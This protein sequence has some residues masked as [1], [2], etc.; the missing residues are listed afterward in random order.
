MV[1]SKIIGTGS[2]LPEKIV[3]NDDMAKFV[4]TSDEWISSRTGIKERRFAADGQLTSELAYNAAIKALK[5]AQVDAEDIDMII[6]ATTTP[7]NTFPSTAAKLHLLLKINEN[8]PTFD[9]QA[10]CS[11]FVYGLS[12]ADSMIK[13]HLAKRILLVG[14]ETMSRILDFNDRATCVL[15][16][17]GAGA[18]VL[19]ATNNNPKK[20]NNP[21][22]LST[23][24]HSN[25]KHYDILKVQGGPSLG[26]EGKLYMDG[27]EVYKVAVNSLSAVVSEA[28]KA[29][30]MEKADIDWLVPHQAN[31]RII[32]SMA[33]KL[34]LGEDNVI[35]TIDKH[36]NTSAAS[37]PLALDEAVQSGR[38]EP[39]QTILMEA[40]GGGMTW[41]AALVRL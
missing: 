12:V 27:P 31:K 1:F 4:D 15:F 21:G 17:D 36:A 5:S 19:E 3:T 39:G 23:H 38:I 18:V 11:G 33:R 14:A 16:G 32:M 10:V 41:A 24:L 22:I 35:I 25:G 13:N 26:Q 37:I 8:I 7:D 30:D 20:N 6:V 2:Y 29:N 40:A 28:L 9:I 34:N